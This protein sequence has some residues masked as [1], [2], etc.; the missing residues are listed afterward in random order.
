MSVIN[1]HILFQCFR[2]KKR[3][4][5]APLA[6]VLGEPELQNADIHVGY[7]HLLQFVC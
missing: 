5:T 6:Q 7:L 3:G 2:L 1:T 4:R